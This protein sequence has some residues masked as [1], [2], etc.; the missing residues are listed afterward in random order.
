MQESV[1]AEIA[2][3]LGLWEEKIQQLNEEIAV[4]QEQME[5]FGVNLSA[6]YSQIEEKQ[7]ETSTTKVRPSDVRMLAVFVLTGARSIIGAK[8]KTTKA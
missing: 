6:F 4:V 2:E 7:A 8:N 1:S 3:Y 5:H